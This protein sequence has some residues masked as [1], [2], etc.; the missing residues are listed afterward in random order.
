MPMPAAS[1]RVSKAGISRLLEP[2]SSLQAFAVTVRFIFRWRNN[3]C[4]E[5]DLEFVLCQR[6]LLKNS[7][8]AVSSGKV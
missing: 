1:Q 4:N 6:A 8:A 7:R 3:R 2:L 5:L